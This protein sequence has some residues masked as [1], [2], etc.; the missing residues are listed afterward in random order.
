MDKASDFG[1]EDCRNRPPESFSWGFVA[2]DVPCAILGADS[3]AAFDLL[4]DCR[5]SRLR[6]KTTNPTVRGISS[7]DVPRQ[8]TVLHPEPENPFRQLLAKYAGLT[9]SNCSASIP[10]HDFVHHT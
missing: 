7:S 10:S 3:L 4:V 6:D 8:L 5:Q 2:A 9:R 1:S